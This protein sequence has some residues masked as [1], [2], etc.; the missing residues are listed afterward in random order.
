LDGCQESCDVLYKVQKE[1]LKQ[2][3]K[4]PKPKLTYAYDPYIKRMVVHVIKGNKMISLA[5]GHITK[6]EGKK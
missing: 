6:L 2:K 1:I 5:T 4:V 3:K